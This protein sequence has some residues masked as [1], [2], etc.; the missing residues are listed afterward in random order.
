MENAQKKVLLVEDEDNIALALGFLIGR[1]GFA[2]SRAATGPE[3]LDALEKETPDLVVLDVM[4]PGCSGYEILQK[5][6]EDQRLQ[7]VKVLM[8]SASGGDVERKK[9]LALGADMFLTKPFSTAQ[10]TEEICRML[11]DPVNG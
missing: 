7:N 5:M 8:M 11:G 4:L 1:Q 6:R 10:L 9:G 2:L 3:A